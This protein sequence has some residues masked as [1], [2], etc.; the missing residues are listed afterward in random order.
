MRIAAGRWEATRFSRSWRGT[1]H[2]ASS[3]CRKVAPKRCKTE[4]KMWIK[5][6]K[7]Y[8]S[9]FNAFTERVRVLIY[10]DPI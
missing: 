5:P 1:A 10:S 4:R 6:H 9:P 2:G 8:V 3:H 7:L